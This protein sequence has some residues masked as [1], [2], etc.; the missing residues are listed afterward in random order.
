M[1]QIEID[2]DRVLA[3][4]QYEIDWG[5]AHDV[6]KIGDDERALVELIKKVGLPMTFRIFNA[7]KM[8]VKIFI[9]DNFTTMGMINKLYRQ[10]GAVSSAFR[11]EGIDEDEMCK[12]IM[13]EMDKRYKEYEELFYKTRDEMEKAGYPNNIIDYIYDGWADN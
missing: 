13:D 12:S 8:E 10:R 7:L 1:K 6:L 9:R 11:D 2:F 3:S 5:P 4:V